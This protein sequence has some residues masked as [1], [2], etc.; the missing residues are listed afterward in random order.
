MMPRLLSFRRSSPKRSSASP[1]RCSRWAALRR[2]AP[3]A[4]WVAVASA[5]VV[6]SGCGG[7]D[8][9]GA[10]GTL[11]SSEFEQDWS[12]SGTGG[13]GP[14]GLRATEAPRSGTGGASGAGPRGAAGGRPRVIVSA[15]E[16]LVT[17]EQGTPARF[18]VQLS[19]RPNSDVQLSFTS[20]DPAEGVVLPGVWIIT[21]EDWNEPK[22][23]LVFGQPDDV[24]DGA[25]SY[26]IALEP[27]QSADPRYAGADPADLVATTEDNDEPELIVLPR[28]V[29]TSESGESGLLEILLNGAPT[30]PVTVRLSTSDASEGVPEVE[31]LEIAPETWSESRLVKVLGSDDAEADGDQDYEVQLVTSSADPRFQGLTVPV[32]GTNL[33]DDASCIRV[34]PR[35]IRISE[36]DG[37]ATFDVALHEAPSAPVTL[38]I[39]SA[40][41]TEAVLFPETLTFTP[42]DWSLTQEITVEGVPDDELDG[43]QPF[44]IIVEVVPGESALSCAPVTVDGISRDTTGVPL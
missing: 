41:P 31:E 30:A 13:S 44:Q 14:R 9:D 20:S 32:L 35:E 10:S 7:A 38:R 1:A 17:D 33:D 4:G 34:Y 43:D 15:T 3:L 18:T 36:R 22:E 6:L 25:Q 24:L 8:P 21:P 29:I 5:A 11:E 37:F 19:A 12:A 2:V 26:T 39:T 40:D 27:A 42:E 28:R 23:V 16:P